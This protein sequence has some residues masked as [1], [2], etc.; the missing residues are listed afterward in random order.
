LGRSGDADRALGELERRAAVFSNVVETRQSLHLRAALALS[1]D[2]TDTALQR[3]TTAAA[4]LPPHGLYALDRHRLLPDHIPI[5][6][7]LAE[8]LRADGRDSESAG[9][10]EQIVE[11]R[12]E[13]RNHP[14]RYARSLFQLAEI[15]DDAGHDQQALALYCRFVDLWADGDLDREQ[16]AAARARLSR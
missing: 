13:S 2:Q 5:W 9:W 7:L 6:Y 10:L 14:V 15:E 12:V 3:L 8:A 4:L 1:R 11:R 16:V